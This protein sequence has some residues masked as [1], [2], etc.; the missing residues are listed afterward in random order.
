[1][2]PARISRFVFDAEPGPGGRVNETEAAGCMKWEKEC[3]P[4]GT[5]P[6]MNIIRVTQLLRSS[7]R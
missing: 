2:S 5:Y 3:H 1:V 6:L 7:S 4:T